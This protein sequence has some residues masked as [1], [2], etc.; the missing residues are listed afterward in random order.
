MRERL[1]SNVIQLLVKAPGNRD[2]LSVSWASTVEG[3]GCQT[4]AI[5]AGQLA[6]NLGD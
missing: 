5:P 2:F 3:Y 6:V 1:V 4:A